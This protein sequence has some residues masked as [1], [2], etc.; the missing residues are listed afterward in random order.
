MPHLKRPALI[1]SALMSAVLIVGCSNEA[2][3]EA[4]PSKAAPTAAAPTEDAASEPAQTQETEEK[5]EPLAAEPATEEAKD[6]AEEEPGSAE[7]TVIA[8]IEEVLGEGGCWDKAEHAP[9]T[10]LAE[11]TGDSAYMDDY[12]AEHGALEGSLVRYG[13]EQHPESAGHPAAPSFISFGFFTSA[14]DFESDKQQLFHATRLLEDAHFYANENELWTA[15]SWS[16][17][18]ETWDY[19]DEIGAPVLSFDDH[20]YK[21]GE[22]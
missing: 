10:S 21:D 11:W 13:C 15:M 16:A 8:A 1:A 2:A 17:T 3:P 9:G 18:P 5:A 22:P 6:A 20:Y 4:A 12:G 14:S 19:L 7:D